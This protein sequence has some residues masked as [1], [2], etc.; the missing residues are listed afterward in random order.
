VIRSALYAAGPQAARIEA[1]WWLMFWVCLAVFVLVI[2]AL[3]IAMA[4][5][6]LRDRELIPQPMVI[7]DGATERRIG[8]AVVA[9]VAVTV[10]VLLVFLI[11]SVI[12]GRAIAS[13]SAPDPVKIEVTGYRWWW[14]VQYSDAVPARMVTTAN[15][16]HIPV[17]RPVLLTLRSR[18]VIHSL[19]VAGL[20]GK[21]DLIPGH[22]NSMWIQAD[23]PGRFE[24][25][26]A[27]FCG[28]Q[29]AH[30]RLLIIADPAEQFDAWLEAQRQ[31]AQPPADPVA[32]RGLEVFQ[33]GTCALCHA[34]QGTEASGQVAPDLTH[35]ASR[36]TIGA[37]TLPN[38]VGNLA[39]WIVDSQHIKPGNA[40]PPNSLASEDLQALLAYL[41]GLK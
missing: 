16:I 25:Q 23:R 35:L 4:R 32:Q 11:A 9:C 37:G 19:W 8:T 30:M 6:R 29:H 14:R 17:G 39:G 34:I 13:L 15:E 12:T 5:G 7:R 21:K 1:L 28:L 2:A 31:P 22:P 24:G 36:I 10:I 20:H 33:T 3:M 27:E 38:S 40:M 41:G 26:C 18:D